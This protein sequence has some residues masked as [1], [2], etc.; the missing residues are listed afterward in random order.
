MTDNVREED[1]RVPVAE[2]PLPFPL[3]YEA[4]Y[5]TNQEAF[6]EYALGILLANERAENA[7]HNAYV[8]I[9]VRWDTLLGEND[10]QAQTWLILRRAI[11]DEL[12]GGLR[13]ELAARDSGIGLYPALAK[14]SPRQF[15]AIVLRYIA[16]YDTKK[17]AL[18]MGLTPGTVT[19]HIRRA[20]ER[21][22]PIHR[23]ATRPIKKEDTQ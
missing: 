17:T 6:H 11:L 14:L 20:Q 19:H 7:V 5:L 16:G 9:R 12:M 21:L 13:E 3:E 10:L 2:A 4:H 23:R 8:E 15:D 1:G 18:Y 22:A